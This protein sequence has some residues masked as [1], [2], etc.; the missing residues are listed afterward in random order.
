M[1]TQGTGFVRELVFLFIL[2]VAVSLLPYLGVLGGWAIS[3]WLGL[4]VEASKFVIM[5]SGLIIGFSLL[6]V[7]LRGK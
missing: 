6:W 2:V 4:G 3:S 1:A 5:I 7:M